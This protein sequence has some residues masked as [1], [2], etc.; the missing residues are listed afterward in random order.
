MTDDRIF[1]L[2]MT[3]DDLSGDLVALISNGRGEGNDVKWWH[4][5]EIPAHTDNEWHV[6]RDL[7]LQ[8]VQ[9]AF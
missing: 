7:L 6:I 9:E 2:S 5:A 3:Y 4:P 1:T 8:F